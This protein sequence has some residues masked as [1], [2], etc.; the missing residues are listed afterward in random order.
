MRCQHP[1]DILGIFNEDARESSVDVNHS[2]SG[3]A[4]EDIQVHR[5][6]GY[7]AIPKSCE[8]CGSSN[9][10]LCRD[11]PE[12]KRPKSYFPKEIPPFCYKGDSKFEG[13]Q[14]SRTMNAVREDVAIKSDENAKST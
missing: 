1:L 4:D 8:Y 2:V 3:D 11:S 9:I 7:Y 13:E 10:D 14:Y 5:P 6:S 12:C